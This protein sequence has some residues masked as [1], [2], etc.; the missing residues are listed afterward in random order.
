MPLRCSI[1]VVTYLGRFESFLKPL[2][3]K[4]HFLFPDYDINVF[5]NGH[6]DSVR[7]IRYLCEVTTF[8]RRY[9]AIRYVTNLTHQPLARGWNWLV[10][11]ARQE[12]VLILND[13]VS[14]DPLFRYELEHV[15]GCREMFT[16]NGSWSHFVINK[17]VIRRVGWFDERFIGVGDEDGDYMCRLA[18]NGIPIVNIAMMGIKNYV[19]DQEDPGWGNLSGVFKNK[20]TRIN[21]EFFLT[22][23]YHSAFSDVPQNAV[24]LRY[25]GE[26]Y[27]VAL[28]EASD[29][30]PEYYPLSILDKG[31]KADEKEAFVVLPKLVCRADYL[32]WTF[33]SMM[34]KF[35]KSFSK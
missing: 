14:V 34:K 35:I 19:A 6:Y 3:A 17:N 15:E 21:R 1:G 32:L 16:I 29:S 13:D 22:K 30:M 24:W 28:K 9:Q 20:Y 12:I 27:R 5:I 4:L 26:E 7:Q 31:V 25:K 18:M 10:I 33:K 23:W 11:M 2:I 8:L